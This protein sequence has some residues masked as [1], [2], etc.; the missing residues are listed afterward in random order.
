MIVVADSS[1]LIGLSSI[2]QLH[3][4][5]MFLNEEIL[6]PSAVW[7][8]VV[9]HGGGRPGAKQIK[10]S[11]WIS[12]RS[13]NDSSLLHLL[14]RDLDAGEAE[15]I[16][17]AKEIKAELILLDERDARKIAQSLSLR[18]LGTVGV[19]IKAKQSER[20]ESLQSMLDALRDQ[21]QFRISNSLY[22]HALEVVGE[23]LSKP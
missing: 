21:A 7:S 15:A 3:L 5:K 17:L 9:E 1:V 10:S 12:V 22:T 11:P 19:L 20:I 16:A 4:L 14:K 6:I 2:G 13:V 8:E 23:K 18:I